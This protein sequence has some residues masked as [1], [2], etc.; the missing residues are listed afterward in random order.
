[1]AGYPGSRPVFEAGAGY[2]GSQPVFQAGAGYPGSQP[3][4]QAGC[5]PK[6]ELVNITF[7]EHIPIGS[8]KVGDKISTWD[9]EQGKVRYTVVTEIHKYTIKE[10][11]SFNNIMQVSSSHPIMIM[12][13]KEN[14]ILIPKWKVAFDINIGDCVVGSNGKYFTVKKKSRYWYTAGIEVLNLSTD[15][16]VPFLIGNIVVRADNARDNVNWSDAPITQKLIAA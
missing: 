15:N 10:I 8:L 12:E 3:V 4:F 5:F 9:M 11:I 14:G 7:D 13:G 1:M 2:P 16:G 6:S